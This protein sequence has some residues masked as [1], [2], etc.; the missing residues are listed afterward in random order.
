M[1][2]LV[3]ERRGGGSLTF[4]RVNSFGLFGSFDLI[5]T[6]RNKSGA[7]FVRLCTQCDVCKRTKEGRR[8]KTSLE[9]LNVSQLVSSL[10]I[11]RYIYRWEVGAHR[12]HTRNM[13]LTE[14]RRT[15][16]AI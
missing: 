7:S 14:A 15:I 6:T 8:E 12:T 9:V 10:F 4:G 5:S 11:N 3:C 13:S 16:I 2:V 1:C